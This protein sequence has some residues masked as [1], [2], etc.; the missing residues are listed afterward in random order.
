MRSNDLKMTRDDVRVK[1]MQALRDDDKDAYAHAMN[2]MFTVIEG[3]IIQKYNDNLEQAQQAADRQ[4]LSSRGVRQ[5]TSEEREYYQKFAD[6]AKS[7]DPKQALTDANIVLPKTV[8]NSV[9]NELQTDHPLLSKIQFINTTGITEMLMN[10]NGKQR[11]QWGKLCDKVVKELLSGFE[12][13]NATLLKL[14]AFIPVCK[15]TLELGPEWLDDFIRQT[16]YEALANG[17]EYGIVCG[18]GAESPIGMTRDVGDGVSVVGGKYPEKQSVAVND[19]QAKT[20]GN[21]LS[22]MAVDRNGNP[23]TLNDVILVVNPQDYYQRVM[24]ATTVMGPDGSYRNDV[25]P[26]PMDV[27]QSNALSCGEAII[28]V[29][30]KYFAGAGMDKSGRIEYSDHCQFMEDNRVYIA[31]LY[32]NGYPVDNNAFLKLDISKLQPIT[33]RVT[34][35]TP[36]AA[37]TN[38]KLASLRVGKLTLSPVFN[39]DTESYTAETED[40]T[41][42]VTAVPADADATIT[43]T[44]THDS[45]QTDTYSNGAAVEWANGSNTLKI[46]VVAADGSTTKEYTV[47]VT[48]S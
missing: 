18:D 14:T 46:K 12:S 32:A 11:A 43:I 27:I 3:E 33:L 22:M 47:T 6:A 21:L 8:I 4:V 26:Y 34:T 1:L 31:K 10:K 40:A 23:R 15:S 29:A 30:D 36:P 25:M 13:V 38:S 9:F 7:S 41:N 44:N 45:D 39:A 20:I 5:L 35:V 28:G 42:T 37:S 17:L 16:L 19:F 2:D 24:P 48:K